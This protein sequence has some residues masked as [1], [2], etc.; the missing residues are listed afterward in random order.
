[1]IMWVFPFFLVQSSFPSWCRFCS[2][3]LRYSVHWICPVSQGPI[4]SAYSDPMTSFFFGPGYLSFFVFLSSVF[5][6]NE[7]TW[8]HSH[9]LSVFL[10]LSFSLTHSPPPPQ[11]THSHWCQQHLFHSRV[12]ALSF[13]FKTLEWKGYGFLGFLPPESSNNDSTTYLR[14]WISKSPFLTEIQFHHFQTG[15]NNTCPLKVLL[16]GK[17]DVHS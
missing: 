3:S 16:Y 17:M 9:S 15:K 5:F 14:L 10:S 11:H 12:H 7:H 8:T 1:M 13:F 6:L 4:G 2:D